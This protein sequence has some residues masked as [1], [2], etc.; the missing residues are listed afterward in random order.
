[1]NPSQSQSEHIPNATENNYMQSL[2]EELEHFVHLSQAQAKQLKHYARLQ[3]QSHQLIESL[4]K[5]L[6]SQDPCPKIT[7]KRNISK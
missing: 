4:K 6:D 7:F 1:M 3:Q 5:K 2:K